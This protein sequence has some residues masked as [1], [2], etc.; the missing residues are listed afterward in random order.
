MPIPGYL[1]EVTFI[2]PVPLG[3]GPELRGL[4][5]IK[6]VREVTLT[7]SYTVKVRFS[8]KSGDD[9]FTIQN[10]L[11]RFMEGVD[12]TA[13]NYGVEKAKIHPLRR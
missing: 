13:G 6:G 11:C 1:C 9:L 4:Y 12:V 8:V 7:Q 5:S 2:I 10:A 3:F